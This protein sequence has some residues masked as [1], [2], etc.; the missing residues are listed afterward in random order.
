MFVTRGQIPGEAEKATAASVVNLGAILIS[1]CVR[2]PLRDNNRM[3]LWA[4]YYQ[5]EPLMRGLLSTYKAHI[6]VA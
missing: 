6:V 5:P 3:I 4:L 1:S 2:C